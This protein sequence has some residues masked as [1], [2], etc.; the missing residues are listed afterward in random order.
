MDIPVFF[1]VVLRELGGSRPSCMHAAYTI[2]E[3]GPK[4]RAIS[5]FIWHGDVLAA[6]CSPKQ[7]GGTSLPD[8]V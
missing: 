4:P 1:N 5:A 2:A 6:T 3:Q 7:Q 8:S